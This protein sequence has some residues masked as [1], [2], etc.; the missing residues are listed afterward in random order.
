M[1]INEGTPRP[2]RAELRQAT[3]MFC[4]MVDSV[5]IAESHP[6]EDYATVLAAFRAAVLAAVVS[7]EGF[8]AQVMGDG[9]L[10]Y[11]GYPV[12]REDAAE[13]AVRAGLEVVRRVPQRDALP[14]LRIQSRV[15]IATGRGLV[16]DLSG[17][18]F[19]EG[20]LVGR[21]PNLASRLQGAAP[22]GAV[23][24]ADS[25]AQVVRHLFEFRQVSLSLK[26]FDEPVP[27]FQALQDLHPE[28]HFNSS[29]GT[30][31]LTRLVGR[32]DE[33]SR[34]GVL[35]QRSVA[36]E[37]QAV[38]MRSLP[39]T[40]KSRLVNAFSET[41]DRSG[42]GKSGSP[43][44]PAVEA[45]YVIHYY[46]LPRYANS[47]LSPVLRRVQQVASI[48]PD[49]P[50]EIALQK[51]DRVLDAAVSGLRREEVGRYLAAAMGMPYEVRY[52]A[53][54]DSPERRRERT[55]QMLRD[56]VQELTRAGPTLIVFE[57]LHWIDPT[58]RELI[59][60]VV[61]FVATQAA[62]VVVTARPGTEPAWIDR[63][64]ASVMDVLP[65]DRLA[66]ETLV[67][68]V[69]GE[70]A[71][72]PGIAQRIVE[73]SDGVPLYLE[74]LTL[75]VLAGGQAPGVPLKLEDLLT[76][77]LDQL[78]DARVTVE[79][80]SVIG[81]E[82]PLSLLYR[83]A[84]L[85]AAMV[86]AHVDRIVN[87]EI[88]S[89]RADVEGAL[90]T[91]RHALIQDAAYDSLP[92]G[93]RRDLHRSVAAA[94]EVERP[95]LAEREPEVLAHHF[96]NGGEPDRA[97]PLLLRAG[98]RAMQRG[99]NAEATQHFEQGLA[100]LAD[101]VDAAT[102][103]RLERTL[104][105]T[106]GLS[107]TATLGYAAPAVETAYARAMTLCIDDDDPDAL[108]P[109][110]RGL[111]TYRIVRGEQQV[112]REL[113]LRCIE[114][115]ERHQR[116]DFLIEG[117]NALG[118]VD[119]YRGELASAAEHLRRVVELYRAHDGASLRYPSAQDPCL[120]ALA[121]L[122]H[123][124]LLQGHEADA[125]AALD[126]AR[127]ETA[128]LG[129]PFERAYLAA[130]EAQFET[131]RGRPADA[132][133]HAQSGIAVSTEFG[134]GNWLGANYMQLGVAF[135]ELGDHEKALAI[136]EP[137]MAGWKAAGAGLALPWFSTGL[138]KALRA[139]GR[140]AEAD[141]ALDEALELAA[142]GG[143]VYMRGRLEGLRASGTD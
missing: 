70:N 2:A 15:G 109:V 32:D 30:A 124:L 114:I 106:M 100:L 68:L 53:I 101:V 51:L 132:I 38:L 139:A 105:S 65:L 35:W 58:T 129:R 125:L 141:Q 92:R 93:R 55:L 111:C 71:L 140:E 128:R 42:R 116:P 59:S 67:E 107:L 127:Q 136:L 11:F 49:D 103:A 10:V 126:E 17:G 64:N 23:F 78:R 77:R 41:V 69:A 5:R 72:A 84:S 104:Q 118:Y 34:L 74:E 14:G 20:F 33:L 12:G 94:L 62:M 8:V 112:A 13:C 122:S 57:D 45:G 75:S 131:M 89:R 137:G 1:G 82:V 60:M 63:P 133:G 98:E 44:P 24:V 66:S 79:V 95:D 120:A 130:Y 96:A 7:N 88:M 83:V 21:V 18:P 80:A 85:D 52:G 28:R 48:T 121:L 26:G 36:G 19:G 143:E 27:A 47:E 43:T 102:R 119:T 108:Y 110:V 31:G 50:P 40:G 73:R 61:D 46:G 123:N 39:G 6:A 134:F 16:G 4:D 138:V 56:N 81:R 22:A 99:A 9:V 142:R 117:H 97:I 37:G 86:D 113:A 90:L 115:G 3:V 91:F 29:R 54:E 76:S 135:A 25:T 87:A